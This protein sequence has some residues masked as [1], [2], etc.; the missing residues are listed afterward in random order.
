[1]KLMR[2]SPAQMAALET[3]GVF[4]PWEGDAEEL[5]IVRA[6]IDGGRITVKLE[7]SRALHELANAADELG[8]EAGLEHDDAAMYR[9]DSRSLTA[10]ACK[11]SRA[12]KPLNGD[13]AVEC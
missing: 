11:V 4:E 13:D 1:M 9:A 6:A 3:S 12:A 10:L 5:A 2:I 8:H 7:V